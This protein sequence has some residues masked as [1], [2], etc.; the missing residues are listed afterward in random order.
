MKNYDRNK[1]PS[2]FKN[3]DFNNFYGWV[4]SQKLLENDFKWVK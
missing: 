2:Y 3:W 4:T 1:E